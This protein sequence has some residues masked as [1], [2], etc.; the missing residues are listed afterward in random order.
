M[1]V[2][3]TVLS[4]GLLVSSSA[5]AA[6]SPQSESRAGFS[7]V[8]RLKLAGNSL[9]DYPF[10]EFVRAFN[11]GSTVEVAVDPSQYPGVVG[12]TADLYLVAHKGEAEWAADPQLIDVRGQP[13]TVTFSDIDITNN[14]FLVDSGTLDGFAGIGLGVPYDVVLD[15]NGDA[16]LDAGDY[17]DGLG[18]E[19]GVYV[20]APTQLPGPLAVSSALYSSGSFLGQVAYF[21]ADIASMGQLPLVVVSHGNGHQYTWYDHIGNHLASYGYIV[22]SHQNARESKP[23]PPR[24]SPIPTI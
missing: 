18:E 20:V 15:F 12:Q 5:V 21:P 2:S 10:F 3:S 4:F 11:Q 8:V 7:G 19:A 23:R 16:L 1:N 24:R 13:Q 9:G 14:T 6:P 22:M 17:I